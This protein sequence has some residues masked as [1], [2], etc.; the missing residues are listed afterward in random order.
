M[1]RM[2]KE[3]EREE[4]GGGKRRE[5]VKRKERQEN[6]YL[7]FHRTRT[8]SFKIVWKSQKT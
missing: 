7:I 6:P 1:G 4:G 5:I 3:Q 8:N 2:R